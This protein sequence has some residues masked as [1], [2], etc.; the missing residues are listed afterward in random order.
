LI[1]ML[2]VFAVLAWF[3]SVIDNLF[4]TYLVGQY[5]SLFRCLLLLRVILPF[6]IC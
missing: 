6:C 3:G 4:L 1:M 5:A 2:G